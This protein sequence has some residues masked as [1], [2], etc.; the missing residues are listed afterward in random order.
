MARLNICW[1]DIVMVF[2]SI[3]PPPKKL[4]VLI[5]SLSADSSMVIIV[6]CVVWDQR[7]AY[8]PLS[9]AIENSTDYLSDVTE[10]KD[11]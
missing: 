11:L 5:N 10:Y 1:R 2:L 7:T 9:T 8:K 3:G 4:N 6:V